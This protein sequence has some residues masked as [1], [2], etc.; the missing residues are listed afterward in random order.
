MPV[1][2]GALS[3]L[4][5]VADVSGYGGEQALKRVV[6]DYWQVAEAGRKSQ[7]MTEILTAAA[8]PSVIRAVGEFISGRKGRK[9]RPG[10][11]GFGPLVHDFGLWC[12]QVTSAVPVRVPPALFPEEVDARYRMGREHIFWRPDWLN[13]AAAIYRAGCRRPEFYHALP[14]PVAFY[15]WAALMLTALRAHPEWLGCRLFLANRMASL[16][17][18]HSGLW[19]L[20]LDRNRTTAEE[21]RDGPT[22]IVG[23]LLDY[24]GAAAGQTRWAQTLGKCRR[25]GCTNWFDARDLRYGYCGACR[26]LGVRVRSER[27]HN[28]PGYRKR[29]RAPG[30]TQRGRP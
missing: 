3:A 26:K 11:Q 5:N 29:R 1:A 21:L 17:V 27:Y 19:F 7:T 23:N 2:L 8:R 16:R 15:F 28:S 24:L 18:V 6:D 12:A 20:L 13:W 9:G 4:E 14:A 30:P 25:P 22:R 10:S